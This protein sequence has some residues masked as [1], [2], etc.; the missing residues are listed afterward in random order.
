MEYW[1]EGESDDPVDLKH[2]TF[3]FTR[4]YHHYSEGGS[5]CKAWEESSAG[6]PYGSCTT[7]R[8]L[9]GFSTDLSGEPMYEIYNALVLLCYIGLEF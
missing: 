2:K 4:A 1:L 3:N 9:Q 6:W 5:S 7:Y 8:T